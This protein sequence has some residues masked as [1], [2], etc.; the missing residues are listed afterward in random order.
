M[1]TNDMSFLKA[2]ILDPKTGYPAGPSRSVNIITE[3]GVFTDGFS[4]PIF[5]A[6]PE[7]GLRGIRK[8]NRDFDMDAI[9]IDNQALYSIG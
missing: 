5:M 1:T 7:N 3:K 4:T 2:K 8:I 6:G 9:M